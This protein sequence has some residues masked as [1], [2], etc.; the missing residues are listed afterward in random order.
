MSRATRSWEMR[1]ACSGRTFSTAK[2][3]EA[4]IMWE[5]GGLTTVAAELLSNITRCL[6]KFPVPDFYCW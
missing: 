5:L 3:Q 4:H 6:I 2:T 1:K